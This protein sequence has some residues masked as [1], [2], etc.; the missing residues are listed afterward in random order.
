[1]AWFETLDAK[2]KA[3]DRRWEAWL[4]RRLSPA[5]DWFIAIYPLLALAIIGALFLL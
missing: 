3:F 1:M 2:C 5:F 4:D